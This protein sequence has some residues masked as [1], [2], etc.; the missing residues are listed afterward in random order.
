MDNEETKSNAGSAP[1]RRSVTGL[2]P[3]PF[4][5]AIRLAY[6]SIPDGK[7]GAKALLIQCEEC[8]ATGPIQENGNQKQLRGKWDIR[9]NEI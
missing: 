8:G 4:C 6:V 2:R 5:G 7:G 9:H 1:P 3:C